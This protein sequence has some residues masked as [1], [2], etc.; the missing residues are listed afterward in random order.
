M[1]LTTAAAG[2]GLAAIRVDQAGIFLTA[3]AVVSLGNQNRIDSLLNLQPSVSTKLSRVC[4]SQR[5]SATSH[6]GDVILQ[7]DDRLALLGSN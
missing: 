1:T 6:K 4:Q 3:R 5:L 7:F 2:V